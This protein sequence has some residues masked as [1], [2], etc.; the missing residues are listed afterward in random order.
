MLHLGVL[1]IQEGEVQWLHSY[2]VPVFVFSYLWMDFYEYQFLEEYYPV[3]HHPHMSWS[4][5]VTLMRT[6]VVAPWAP[7]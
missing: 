1:M 6:Q 7:P 2:E 3:E 4:L 5:M